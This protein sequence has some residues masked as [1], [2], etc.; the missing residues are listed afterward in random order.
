MTT[1]RPVDSTRD[2]RGASAV[3]YALLAA[4]SAAGLFT[5]MSTLGTRIIPLYDL[6]F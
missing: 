3:E 2:E 6:V 1:P 4:L 5:A